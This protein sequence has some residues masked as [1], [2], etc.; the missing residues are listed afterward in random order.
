MLG[1]PLND[2]IEIVSYEHKDYDVHITVL[3]NV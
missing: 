2:I 1:L 3:Y